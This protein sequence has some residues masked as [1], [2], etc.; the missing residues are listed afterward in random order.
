MVSDLSIPNFI[1]IGSEKAGTTTI[2]NA[3]ALQKSVFIPK[4]K[5]IH[6]FSNNWDKGLNWYKNYFDN[7]VKIKGE[8]SPSYTDYPLIKDVPERIYKTLP[9]VKLL[10]VLRN[11]IKRIISQYRHALYYNWISKNLDFEEAIIYRPQLID[12]GKYYFQI[13]Q[14]LRFFDKNQIKIICIEEINE[15]GFFESVYEF[16]NINDPIIRKIKNEN[17]TGDKFIFPKYLEFARKSDIIRKIAGSY[18]NEGILINRYYNVLKLFNKDKIPYPI[19]STEMRQ[20]LLD[21]YYT[22]IADLSKLTNINF[23]RIWKL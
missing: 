8:A 9:N 14:Y 19:I 20:K 18:H 17:K 13:K 2:S 1:I 5:E 15:P 3:I 23:E 21:I 12:T 22:D 6:F 16:L 10:Y 4:I 7:N 11:P